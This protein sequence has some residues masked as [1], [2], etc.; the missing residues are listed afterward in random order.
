MDHTPL[1]Y[2]VNDMST[3]DVTQVAALEKLIFPLPWSALAFEY[4]L[5]HNPMAHFA[6]LR[7][8]APVDE[9][10]SSPPILGY[11]GFWLIVN[12]AHICTLGVHPDWRGRGLGELLLTNLIDRASERGA[13]VATLEVRASNHVA[14]S[15][16]RKYGFE[17]TGRRKGYY[18]DNAEDAIIMTTGAIASQSYQR[19]FT[20]LKAELY[21]R[22]DQSKGPVPMAGS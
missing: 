16:Y 21:Q 3:A 6:V 4:E 13:A 11:A 12:E 8:R 7:R 15:M 17:I 1:P 14:Q 10:A 5:R 9:T 20:V 22:L 18:S 19:R 2:V